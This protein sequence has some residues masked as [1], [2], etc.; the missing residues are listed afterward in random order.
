M[1]EKDQILPSITTVGKA[2]WRT[3]IKDARDLGI[4]EAGLFLNGLDMKGRAELC[5][6]LGDSSITSIPVVHL[7]NDVTEMEVEYFF[8]EYST[9]VFT[10]HSGAEYPFYTALP[11]FEKNIFIENTSILFN[12]NELRRYGGI[13]LNI[14]H[15]ENERLHDRERYDY[16]RNLLDVYL[17]GCNYISA[18]KKEI[19]SDAGRPQHDSYFLKNNSE[20]DY[21][22]NYPKNYFSNFIVLELENDLKTQLEAKDHIFDLIKDRY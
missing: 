2:D 13:C 18:M 6:L 7:K 3:Q 11:K 1:L 16:F 4:T 14:S 20:L 21:I 5:D 12:E 10:T 8:N 9:K 19:L 17:V 22:L 15:L